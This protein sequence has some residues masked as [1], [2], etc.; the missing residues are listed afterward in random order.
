MAVKIGVSKSSER[1]YAYMMV[2][3]V[4][5]GYIKVGE[6][7]SK[8]GYENCKSLLDEQKF[9]NRGD[10]VI[11]SSA[12]DSAK[13]IAP[14]STGCSH[15]PMAETSAASLRERRAVFL[16]NTAMEILGMKGYK[17]PHLYHL[18][19]SAVNCDMGELKQQLN[20]RS[21]RASDL[22]RALLRAT[23]RDGRFRLIA[24]DGSDAEFL[25]ALVSNEITQNDDCMAQRNPHGLYHPHTHAIITSDVSLDVDASLDVIFD[26]WKKQNPGLKVDRKA[27][28]LKPAYGSDSLRQSVIQATDYV[29]KPT[30][31]KGFSDIVNHDSE[32]DDFAV[33]A[34]AE[35]QNAIHG[36]KGKRNKGVWDLAQGFVRWVMEPYNKETLGS[37]ALAGFYKG[38]ESDS[39]NVPSVLTQVAVH[40]FT[41]DSYRFTSSELMS[42]DM[43]LWANRELLNGVHFEIPKN[44]D[45]PKNNK[46][47]ELYRKLLERLMMP[48]SG[49][50]G[51][52]TMISSWYDTLTT[53]A[54]KLT[55]SKNRAEYKYR[56]DLEKS[57]VFVDPDN[58]D[59]C[60]PVAMS[61][62]RDLDR[63]KSKMFDVK[64]LYDA[65]YDLVDVDTA[66]RLARGSNSDVDVRDYDLG[67]HYRIKANYRL[68]LKLV[69]MFESMRGLDKKYPDQKWTNE[70]STSKKE[71]IIVNQYFSDSNTKF[72][73]RGVYSLYKVYCKM[74]QDA[75]VSLVTRYNDEELKDMRRTETQHFEPLNDGSNMYRLSYRMSWC[76]QL[77]KHGITHLTLRPVSVCQNGVLSDGMVVV[78][79]VMDWALSII[80][81]NWDEVASD[82]SISCL[83]SMGARTFQDKVNDIGKPKAKKPT[84]KKANYASLFVDVA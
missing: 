35:I 18:V 17:R 3:A 51:L 72:L 8:A 10:V 7:V 61:Y 64:Q 13:M 29:V 65:V 73:P 26:Y 15:S 53:K 42:K 55:A 45:W 25:G 44:M 43:L 1:S 33:K 56:D 41:K 63:V 20:V 81:E 70:H 32:E 2:R 22:L 79:D 9:V 27:S 38:H 58:D 5:L 75:F 62:Q 48:G 19:L 82:R 59:L 21:N 28:F 37:A 46:K 6:G 66:R 49:K 67:G 71:S 78:N 4:E 68:R 16:V 60:S 14:V 77:Q 31:M 52:L 50:T 11:A 83:S 84:R 69:S 12:F 36:F 74:G 30:Y 57:G 23:E 47:A 34:F 24:D 80:S 39:V 54:Q 76:V 40:R